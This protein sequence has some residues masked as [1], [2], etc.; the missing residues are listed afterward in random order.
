MSTPQNAIEMLDE[1]VKRLDESIRSDDPLH[2]RDSR[3][4]PDDG[5]D[6]YITIAE[7]AVIDRHRAEK[8]RQ[9]DSLALLSDY[10]RRHP[11]DKPE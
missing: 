6:N 9:R 4:K 5:Y 8:I 2:M 10:L 11:D 3:A 1:E 7:A